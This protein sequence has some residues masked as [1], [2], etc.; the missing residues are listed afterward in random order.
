MTGL[1]LLV[2]DSLMSSPVIYRLLTPIP[3]FFGITPPRRLFNATSDSLI[4]VYSQVT[5]LQLGITATVIIKIV[6]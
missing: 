5:V 3:V 6:M 1:I 2:A 4:L